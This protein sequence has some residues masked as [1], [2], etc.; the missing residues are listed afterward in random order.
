MT[1]INEIVDEYFESV[2]LAEKGERAFGTVFW[3]K[4]YYPHQLL[5]I[6]RP[7]DANTGIATFAKHFEIVNPNDC[8]GFKSV[9]L[10]SPK[11]ELEEEFV[12]IKAKPRPVVVLIPKVDIP[13]AKIPA[14]MTIARPFALVAQIFSIQEKYSGESKLPADF[15]SDIQHLKY[16]QLMFLPKGG[17]LQTDSLL[18]L[19]ECQSNFS[20]SLEPTGFRFSSD[21]KELLRAQFRIHSGNIDQDKHYQTL[22]DMCQGN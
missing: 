12:V 7:S 14:G 13:V 10:A 2:P 5:E 17:P 8:D 3:A 15:L 16:P 20:Q 1:P 6:W 22:S 18:R 21:I 19:D 4:A 11:L 9:V